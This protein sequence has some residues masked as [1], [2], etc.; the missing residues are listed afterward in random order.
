[1]NRRSATV[2]LARWSATHPRRAVGLWLLLVAGCVAV[3]AA[4]PTR[5]LQPAD[6]RIGES[7]RA[8]AIVADSGLTDPAREHVVV[9]ARSGALD[10][11]AADAA[12][13][14]AAARLR[15]LPGVAAVDPPVPAADGSALVVPVTLAGDPATAGDRV[16]PLL[17]A[18][19]AAQAAHPAL[20]VEQT[21]PASLDRGI[22]DRVAADLG[23][24][25]LFSL[26]VTLLI[27][28]VAFGAVVAA[29]LPVLL[30]G[31]SV[32]AAFGLAALVS[33]AVPS[34]DTIGSMIVLIGMAVGVD[35]S[36]FYL[37]REREERARGAG[38]VDAVEIAAATSGHSVLVSGLAVIVS[39][40]GLYL[41]RDATF[42]S[43]ATGAIIVVA[44]AVLGSLTV[45]P[46]LLAGLGARV[47][48]LR[49]PLLWRLTSRGGAP[50]FVPVLLR[51]ALR[52][53]LA[54]LL[55]AAAGMGAL[56]LPALDLRTQ[57]GSLE[58]LPRSIPAVRAYDRLLAALPERGTTFVVAVRGTA[59]DAAAVRSALTGL[60]AAA[61][62]DPA[63]GAG[64]GRAAAVRAS[65]DGRVHLLDVA[66]PHRPTGAGADAA[67]A[68]L[69]GRLAPAALGGLAGAEYA[70]GGEVAGNADAAAHQRGKLPWVIGFVLL[71]TFAVMTATFRSVVVGLTA[72]AVNLLSAVAAFGVL[73]LVFQREWAQGLLDFRS[74]GA[75]IDWIP[76]FLFVVLFGL[77][78]DYHVFVVQRI[79]EAV[80]GGLP[81][82][83]A[84]VKGITGS[85]GVITSAAVVMVAV[86]AIFATLSMVE[87]KQIG[88]GLSTAILLDA[89]VVRIL[90]LPALM[91]LLGR[92]NWWAPRFLR[93]RPA[94]P[95]AD[96]PAPERDLLVSR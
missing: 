67:L 26:P 76:L 15:A 46:A 80:D 79:R 18:T 12:A 16:R 27:L 71:L 70:V 47:D 65:A 52:H 87:M 63:V 51:P 72:V 88:I 25:E 66:A 29:G 77:S 3:A 44:V 23:R 35:Y 5:T 11:A 10:R 34:A 69:R 41:A 19:A 37:R 31:T 7:G 64:A 90:I 74:T 49:I 96:L 83:A 9:T 21:G 84:V 56:A 17:D 73:V 89:V 38:P 58:T 40:G 54:T 55:V 4:V 42:A 28:L 53:P 93:R 86:F 78:M 30:A 95:P 13:A 50:R 75:V 62:R 81:T 60:A 43:L 82:R 85:A 57:S 2:R 48:R 59:G 32:A 39:M 20:R 1:M 91:A 14:D 36:L 33:Y 6:Y 92:V 45:L 61:H 22:D 24:A 94:P 68:A 8:E